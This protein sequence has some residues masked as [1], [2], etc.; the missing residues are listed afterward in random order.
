[1]RALLVYPQI[2]DTF[3]SF[4]HALKFIAKKAMHPPLGLL[5]IAAML[6]KDWEIK[7]VDE[8][9]ESLSDRHLQ[10]ADM[11]FIS[12]MAIQRGSVK[13][14]VARCKDAGVKV[15]AGGPLF[16][17]SHHEFQDIDHFVL[18]EAEVSLPGFLRDL[19]AGCAG[20]HYEAGQFPDLDGTP[21]PRWDLIKLRRYASM[22]LQYS[23]GCPYNCEFCDIT[24][25]F[26][27][28]VRTKG[29]GQLLAELDGLHAAGWRG[30]V[31][32]VDDNFIGNKPKLKREVLPA[33]IQWMERWHRPFAFSTEASID[34][35]DDEELMQLMVRAGFEGVFIGIESPSEASLAECGKLQNK[36]RDLVACVRKIQSFGMEVRGGFIVGFD[37]DSPEVF[38]KQI[39]LIQNSRIVTAMVGL[40]NA[41]RGSRLYQR[42]A[43][44]GRLLREVSGD[45]TDFFTNLEPKMG[46]DVLYQGYRRV[47][48][49]IYAPGPYYERVKAYLREYR[50]PKTNHFH[51]HPALLRLH[52]GYSLAFFKSVLLLGIK[53]RARWH[54]WKLLLWSIFRQ[55]RLLPKAITFAIYGFHFRKVFLARAR[56]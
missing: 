53:D 24:T 9:V 23:R 46:L 54:Y 21:P 30:S 38:E 37:H 15:V 50:F 39:D 18:G 13:R 47:I 7:L 35:S 10:W 36:G 26:G 52:S 40:L 17:S 20:P 5:T 49:G 14:L 16:T 22:S 55:P 45:N 11:T 25:L 27:R 6:P 42:I 44:E 43:Q 8:N 56:P 2:P 1:M 4:K 34:L 19:E 41:P 29:A 3:W 28:K 48:A 31:F 51:F 33:L 12:A 32:I